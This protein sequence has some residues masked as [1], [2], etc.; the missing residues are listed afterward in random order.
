LDDLR[1]LKLIDFEYV[2]WNPRA[3]DLAGYFN[4]MMVD[5]S[6]KSRRHGIRSYVDNCPSE[7]NI[8]CACRA[9]LKRH[10]ETLFAEVDERE[11]F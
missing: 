6:G 8:E 11:E 1:V 9:Y 5:K 3:M 2:G 10:A 7:D 4:E